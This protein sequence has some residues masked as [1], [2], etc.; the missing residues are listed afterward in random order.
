MIAAFDRAAVR[1]IGETDSRL[2]DLVMPR[3][4]RLANRGLLWIGVASVLRATGDRWRGGPPG[5]AWPQERRHQHPRQEPDGPGPPTRQGSRSP[6][7]Q[8]GSQDHLVPV[9][10][11]RVCGRLRHWRG[12]GEA[13]PRRARHHRRCGRGSVAGGHR[14]ALSVR[15][16]RR[17]HDRRGRR[18]VDAALVAAAAPGS[19]RSDQAPRGAPAVPSGEDLVLAVNRSAG[20][21]SAKLVRRLR[22]ERLLDRIDAPHLARVRAARAAARE[23]AWEAG[24]APE[25]GGELRIDFD[26][27]ISIAHRTGTERGG[28]LEEDIRI[29]PGA[30]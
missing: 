6:A 21:T 10:A 27:T 22:A 18:G 4:S 24:A 2:L 11:R 29:P 25:R 1:R 26:A 5:A 16:P 8:P 28:H 15:R 14:D 3:L 9:R 17:V 30:P 23:R 12:A 19:G 13:K 7:A 20:T